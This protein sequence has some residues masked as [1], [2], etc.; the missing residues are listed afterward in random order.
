MVHGVNGKCAMVLSRTVPSFETG[1]WEFPVIINVEVEL[2]PPILVV[3]SF[4]GAVLQESCIVLDVYTKLLINLVM[5]VSLVRLLSVDAV[6]CV[7]FLLLGNIVEPYA[8][9]CVTEELVLPPPPSAAAPVLVCGG[10]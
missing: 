6:A 1:L 4:P 7:E 9:D 10:N 8:P 5:S 2:R 3:N